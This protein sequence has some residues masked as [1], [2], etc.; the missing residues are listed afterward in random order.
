MD[1]WSKKKKMRNNWTYF[2]VCLFATI[3]NIYHNIFKKKN[4]SRYIDSTLSNIY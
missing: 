3:Y 2:T 1:Q 4:S